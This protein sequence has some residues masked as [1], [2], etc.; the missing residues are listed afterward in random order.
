MIKFVIGLMV[1]L[2]CVVFFFQN[3]D[4]SN[5]N[6]F[7]WTL[8]LPLY[9]IMLIFFVSGIFLGW[10]LTSLVSLKKHKRRK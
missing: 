8:S 10:L 5:I 3:G 6:F 9:L 2:V 7:S 1:G 4:I